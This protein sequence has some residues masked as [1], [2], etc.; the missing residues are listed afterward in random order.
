MVIRN[1]ISESAFLVNESR[2]RRVELSRDVYAKLWT[3]DYTKDLWNEFTSKVYPY[4]DIELSLRNRFFLERLDSYIDSTNNPI[5]VN[6]ASGFTSYP[7]LVRN[8][9]KCVEVDF[10]HVI[11]F[12]R[13]KIEMWKQMGK[14]PRRS[15]RFFPADICN[16]KDVEHLRGF[17]KSLLKKESSFILLE[18]I[19][20]YLD[21]SAL[22]YLFDMLSD[23][24]NPCSVLT[25]DFWK[26]ENAIHPVFKRFSKYFTERFGF[27][28]TKY[29]FFDVDFICS[30]NGYELVEVRNIQELENLYSST[31]LLKDYENILPENYAVL[32][33]C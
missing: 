16:K 26:T 32:Q 25:F 11:D 13:E 22:T 5:F 19:T 12:K 28:E 21:M 29:N 14:L 6:I 15:I 1:T 3:S 24:Q 20:Y 30:I 8:T 18:G 27:K 10:K 33:K 17:L 23:V 31:T 9:C 2:A 7:F 4:D